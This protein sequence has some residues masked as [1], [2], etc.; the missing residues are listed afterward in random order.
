[1][2]IVDISHLKTEDI[3]YTGC[4]PEI[5]ACLRAG[6]AVWCKVETGEEE[7]IC[8]YTRTGDRYPFLT[9]Q[10][11]FTMATTIKKKKKVW[12][13]KGCVALM[14]EFV[15]R[16]YKPD[17]DGIWWVDKENY[18]YSKNIWTTCGKQADPETSEKWMLEEVGA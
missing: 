3:D 16:G 9:D 7:L 4:H 5:E 11:R 18:G 6:K 13:V 1:M 8:G 17:E 14:Q 2:N 10:T 12:K 15:D